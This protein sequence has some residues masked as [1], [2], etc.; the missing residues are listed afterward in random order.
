MK[1]DGQVHLQ[2][3][4][5]LQ[6]KSKMEFR[7]A[8]SIRYEQHDPTSLDVE[9]LYLGDEEERA[10]M[11]RASRAI[12]NNRLTLHAIDDANESINLIG[13]SRWQSDTSKLNLEVS[14]I[15]VGIDRDSS[16]YPVKARFVVALQ[17]S[18]ILIEPAIH[19]RYDSGDIGVRKLGEGMIVVDSRVGPIRATESYDFLERSAFGDKVTHRVQRAQLSGEL[20]LRPGQSLRE[21]HDVLLEEVSTICR[22]LSFCYRQP[23]AAYEIAYFETYPGQHGYKKSL[24]RRKWH[25]PRRKQKEEELIHTSNLQEGGLSLLVAQ[26]RL[27]PEAEALS[28]GVGFLSS[29]YVSSLETGYFMAF[30]AME[31]IVN[32]MSRESD[33]SRLSSSSWRKVQKRLKEALLR[34]EAEGVASLENV[35]LMV[36]KLPELRRA[37]LLSRVVTAV[38][39]YSVKSMTSG[40]E[41]ALSRVCFKPAT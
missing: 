34:C 25:S 11:Y 10:E 33:Q 37:T 15:E 24:Y 18:G 8:A 3:H 40:P 16:S 7:C 12:D 5:A 30:S 14:A 31:T 17:P 13:L 21:L 29:S 1:V 9:L 41:K 4:V 38:E 26:M 39:V 27:H 20:E 2:F 28:R 32:A 36:D 35:Q 22:A 6:P 19:S 23:V